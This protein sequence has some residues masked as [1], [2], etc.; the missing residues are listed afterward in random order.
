MLRHE[1]AVLRRQVGWPRL[2]WADRAVFAALTQLLSQAAEC[3]GS[4]PPSR[5]AL[6]PGPGDATL[7][8]VSTPPHRRPFHRI[9]VAP[10]GAATG[11]GEPTWAIGGSRTNLPS[12]AT[13]LRPARCVDP[14]ASQRGSSTSP[15]QP[16]L[17]TV[18]DRPAH[19]ILATG[20]FCVDTQL[21]HRL[22]VLFVVE[23]ATR[24][25]PPPGHHGEPDRSL[26]YSAGAGIS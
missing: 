7:D 10:A 21:L 8:P 24:P 16:H 1:V 2:S 19:G 12:S 20:F 26:G 6:A 22:Y 23:H 14:E 3:I 13:S 5:C 17:A 15:Q 11:F 9:R 18:P 25:R 4:S